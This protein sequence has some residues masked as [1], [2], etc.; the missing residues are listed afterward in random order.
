MNNRN[1]STQFKGIIIHLIQQ[2]SNEMNNENTREAVSYK[3]IF[4]YSGG[5]QVNTIL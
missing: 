1:V 5:T 3:Q 4:F 2:H